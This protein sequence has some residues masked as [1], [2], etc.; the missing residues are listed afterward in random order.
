MKNFELFEDYQL[1]DHF[2]L[3][4][5]KLVCTNHIENDYINDFVK[6]N[7]VTGVCHYCQKETNAT[8]LGNLMRYIGSKIMTAY[9]KPNNMNLPLAVHTESM[10]ASAV[11]KETEFSTNLYE[12][13]KDIENCFYTI[14]WIRHNP[15]DIDKQEELQYMWDSFVNKVKHQRRFKSSEIEILVD[16]YHGKKS[17]DLW[18]V[19]EQII[20][21]YDL[22]TTL[23]VNHKIYRCRFVDDI[24]KINKFKDITSP[25][26]KNASQSR[27]SPLGISMFYGAFDRKT[28]KLE[29]S[30]KGNGNSEQD[31][32]AGEFSL[33][34]DLIVLDLT[35]LPD[36]DFWAPCDSNTATFLN[37]FSNDI[38]KRI[39]RDDRIH[40]E[41]I[42]TQI[43]T[44]YFKYE[45][46]CEDGKKLD[47][48]IFKSSIAGSTSNNIVLFYDQKQSE[49]ILDLHLLQTIEDKW[50]EVPIIDK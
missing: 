24:N 23:P 19:I 17:V 39:E 37:Y 47:G 36:S 48:I 34:K 38:S 7:S 13:D 15:F 18:Q 27:M 49:E 20:S 35:K 44:E 16:T 29:S 3:D 45:Y 41:Y 14:D 31:C 2:N 32:V 12:L 33:R 6:A 50:I 10:G 4:C 43:L 11:L 28:A 21:D 42:P 9:D 46:R 1:E 8:S 40:L 5:D 26:D 25:P 22:C 30:P